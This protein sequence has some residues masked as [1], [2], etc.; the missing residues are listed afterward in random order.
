MTNRHRWGHRNNMDS[1]YPNLYS[2]L[3]KANISIAR[4]AEILTITEAAVCD[5]LQGCKPWLLPEVIAICQLLNTSNVDFLF[6]RL[7]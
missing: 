5:K 1:I 6:L 2:E 7:V 3:S 4:L